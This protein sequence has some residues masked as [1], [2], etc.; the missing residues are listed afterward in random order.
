[1]VSDRSERKLTG[2]WSEGLGIRLASAQQPAGQLSG[3]N[4]QKVSLAKWLAADCDI[5]IVDEP[6]VGI[7]VRTKAAFH[8]LIAELAAGGRALLLIS[9]DLPETVAL[10]DRIAVMS[11]LKIVG[12]LVN[13][14]DYQRMSQQIIR[15]IHAETHVEA[16]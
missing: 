10:A 13:N 8:Q 6:T 9:S 11:E 14:H 4:Q 1:L 15:M 12:E 7:D 3:G 5:L 16:A 2:K